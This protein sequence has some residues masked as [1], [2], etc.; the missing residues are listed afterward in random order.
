MTRRDLAHWY[1]GRSITFSNDERSE[2]FWMLDTPGLKERLVVCFEEDPRPEVVGALEAEG[3]PHV[4]V[5]LSRAMRR[6]PA[7]VFGPSPVRRAL[8]LGIATAVSAAIVGLGRKRWAAVSAAMFRYAIT[9]AFWTDF[10]ARNPTR[11]SMNQNDMSRLHL[12]MSEALADSGGVSVTHQW[13]NLRLPSIQM[14]NSSDVVFGFGPAYRWHWET[15]DSAIRRLVWVGY[16]TDHAFGAVRAPA[17]RLRERLVAAGARFIVCFFDENSSDDRLSIIPNERAVAVHRELLSR[18]LAEPDLGLILKPGFP[19][20]FRARM[21][22]ISDLLEAALATGRLVIVEAS[23]GH[24]T[25][26]YP[27]ETAVA[28]DLAVGLLLSGTAALESWLAGAPTVFLDLEGLKDDPVYE[29]GRGTLVF[30]SV[31]ALM[32]AAARWRQDADSV[33]GFGD[34]ERW[35]E[36]KDPFRDGRASERIGRYVAELLGALDDGASPADAITRADDAHRRDWG[37]EAV[38]EWR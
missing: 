36:G 14:A 15:S 33:P 5:G 34:L 25:D 4:V 24:K 7:L 16:V 37:A 11:V 8:V 21:S 17:A 10:Y 32:D 9:H 2:L 22:P 27:A 12:P 26:A 1:T 18:L 3:V 23:G 29:Y 28:A 38:I 13:S 20:T 6:L 19:R 31:P 35:A 30:E